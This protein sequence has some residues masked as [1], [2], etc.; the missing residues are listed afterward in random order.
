MIS[1]GGDRVLKTSTKAMIL[2]AGK[3]TRM[4]PLTETLPK[5]LLLVQGISL[6]EHRILALKEAGFVDKN[7][8]QFFLANGERANAITFAEGSF[9]EESLAIQVERSRFETGFVPRCSWTLTCT[10]RAWTVSRVM[11]SRERAGIDQSQK[12]PIGDSARACAA[13]WTR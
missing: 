11:R 4:L 8:A 7:G 10:Q 1:L 3:G 12:M 13:L 6:L 5:P 2:A 9:T